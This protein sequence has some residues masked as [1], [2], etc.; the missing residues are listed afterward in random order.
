VARAV[1]VPARLNADLELFAPVGAIAGLPF[2]V[3]VLGS[4]A[5]DSEEVTA[6]EAGYRWRTSERLAFDFAVFDNYYDRLQTQEASPLTP[7]P[8]PPA[9]FLLQASLANLMEGETYGGTVAVN[10][11]PL[12]QWRLQLHYSHLQMDLTRKP[13]SNDAGAA[14]VAGNSP[15]TQVAVRSYRELPGDFSLY[16]GAR[17]VAEL[18]AQRVPSYT[19]LDFGLEW[20]P[21]GRPLRVALAVQNANDDRHLEFGGD[22][23]IERSAF[24]RASWSF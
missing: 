23:Y 11:Q 9:Y 10:W 7:V 19:A 15:Q 20:Q 8:G 16:A 24:A 14:N 5:F 2:Y 12:P 18:P 1:R 22:T 21:T 17:Y 4:D 3:N 13:G 6:Y